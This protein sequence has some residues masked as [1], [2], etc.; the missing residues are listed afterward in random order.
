MKKILVTL[1]LIV[2]SFGA[3]AQELVW[4]RDVNKAL[5]ISQKS[6]KPNVKCHP[7]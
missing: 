3:E 5:E 2:G 1:L 6:K 4:E 7:R